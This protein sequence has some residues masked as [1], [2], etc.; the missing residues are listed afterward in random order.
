MRC[1]GA[2]PVFANETNGEIIARTRQDGATA[3]KFVVKVHLINL[4]AANSCHDSLAK[5][6]PPVAS[7]LAAWPLACSAAANDNSMSFF[8]Y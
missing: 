1:N 4:A 2:M 5:C 3:Q 6:W 7:R 8:Y